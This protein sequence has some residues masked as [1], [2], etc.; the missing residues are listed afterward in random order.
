MTGLCGPLAA[1]R[2]AAEKPWLTCRLDP[3]RPN[4]ILIEGQWL[5]LGSDP[6]AVELHFYID[7]SVIECFANH[8][9]TLTQ[10]VYFAGASAPPLTV[11]I[12]GSLQNLS[13]L[14]VW[15]LAPISP[16]RLTT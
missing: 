3:S 13:A 11:Q 10:R 14:S 1:P 6:G 9:G 7:G 4:E 16:N 2:N 5:P 15:Q 8:H 12:Q